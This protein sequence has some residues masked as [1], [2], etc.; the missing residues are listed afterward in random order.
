MKVAGD[1]F[2][3]DLSIPV[4]SIGDL[5]NSSLTGDE[6]RAT[7]NLEFSTQG[8]KLVNNLPNFLLVG[9]ECYV[10]HW[11]YHYLNKIDSIQY[12]SS[13]IDDATYNSG[14]SLGNRNEV[15]A[16]FYI[17]DEMQLIKDVILNTS[18]RFNYDEVY[19]NFQNDFVGVSTPPR[20]SLVYISKKIKVKVRCLS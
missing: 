20:V 3:K 13:L 1:H 8:L 10:N 9:A 11:G 14:I 7:V 16:A 6:Y 2:F 19:S 4:W 15:F 18:I 5:Y 12:T 17:Q